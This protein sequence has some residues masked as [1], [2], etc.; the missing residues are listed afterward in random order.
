MSQQP[1]EVVAGKLDLYLAPVG[2]TYP[3]I[4]ATP[5]ADWVKLGTNGSRNYSEDGV[6]IAHPQSVEFWRALGSTGPIKAMRGEE[7]LRVSLTVH[8]LTLEA[9]AVALNHNTVG[10]TAPTVSAGGYKKI[11]LSRGLDVTQKALLVRGA[12]SAYGANW[13]LQLEVPIVVQ[14]AEP[15]VVVSKTEPA[16]LA[17]EFAALEDPNATSEAERFGRLKMQNADATT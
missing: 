15:E 11:G 8:D 6:T 13:N 16:G 1:F 12:C 7:E 10:T 5:A 9:Y 2:T 17:L 14:A 3:D 4:D